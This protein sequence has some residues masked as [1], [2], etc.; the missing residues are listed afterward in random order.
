MREMS[1]SAVA[2]AG[3]RAPRSPADTRRAVVSSARSGSSAQYT[4]VV[5]SAIVTSNDATMISSAYWLRASR[6]TMNAATLITRSAATSLI[7]SGASS[8]RRRR[9]VGTLP[10]APAA[11]PPAARPATSTAT[12]G[13]GPVVP[14][15]WGAGEGWSVGDR[16]LTRLGNGEVGRAG[17]P[18]PSSRDG[19]DQAGEG[20]WSAVGPA[21]PPPPPP[22]HQQRPQGS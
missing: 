12:S 8:R 11:A 3:T 4:S 7:S 15:L 14:R 17:G 19:R 18:A 1:R 22:V 21:G 13:C 9:P 10:A 6:M 16:V 5:L 2:A 20:R